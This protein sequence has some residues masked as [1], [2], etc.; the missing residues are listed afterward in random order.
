MTT[1]NHPN[2]NLIFGERLYYL[3][4]N[5][6][7]DLFGVQEHLSKSLCNAGLES[8]SCAYFIFGESDI[9]L[10]VWAS[11]TQLNTFERV[12]KDSG[13]DV[14]TKA[15]LV[16]NQDTWYQREIEKRSEWNS[17]FSPENVLSA[18]QK[19]ELPEVIQFRLESP[20]TPG[21]TKF[22]VIV[23]EPFGKTSDVFKLLQNDVR[24]E[25]PTFL[26]GVQKVSLYA[27]STD[28]FRGILIKGETNDY[29][30]VSERLVLFAKDLKLKEFAAQTTTYFCAKVIKTEETEISRNSRNHASLRKPELV[31]NLL[32]AHD[33]HEGQWRSDSKTH[34]RSEAFKTIVANH[35]EYL[36]EQHPKW[37]RQ[38]NE[39]RRLYRWIVRKHD[40]NLRGFLITQY[41]GLEKYFRTLFEPHPE[42]WRDN[43][44]NPRVAG[45]MAKTLGKPQQEVLDALFEATKEEGGR[46]EFTLRN[47]RDCARAAKEI[48]ANEKTNKLIDQFSR[49]LEGQDG[50]AGLIRN[51]NDLM[52]GNVTSIFNETEPNELWTQFVDNYIQFTLLFPKL[53]IAFESALKQEAKLAEIKIKKLQK[54]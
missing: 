44:K 5:V 52:H 51:R 15:Y 8:T 41:I 6:K 24:Q 47:L 46:D 1:L 16:I 50:R 25:P 49:L 30:S 7:S 4:I 36:F 2:C 9:L 32:K 19:G 35:F 39:I 17:C 14:E 11:E 27:F 26:R 38:L 22:F 13:N 34:A 28:R 31:Y 43:A 42:L 18:L 21:T 53:Q 23:E 40:E 29:H 10:R 20:V 3:L 48:H 33:C 54:N 45:K 12:L 37:W